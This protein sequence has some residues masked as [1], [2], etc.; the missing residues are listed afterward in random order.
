MHASGDYTIAD[1]SELFSFSRPTVYRTLRRNREW[2]G[3][4]SQVKEGIGSV[5]AS[6]RFREGF[7][8]KGSRRPLYYVWL[9]I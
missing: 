8:F 6:V 9:F 4:G 2:V 3:I 7:V 5:F 1:L